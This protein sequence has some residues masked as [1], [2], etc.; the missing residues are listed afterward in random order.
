MTGKSICDQCQLVESLLQAARAAF[1]AS[2]AVPERV[3]LLRLTDALARVLVVLESAGEGPT[4][5]GQLSAAAD[6]LLPVLSQIG[7]L[8]PSWTQR[9]LFALNK[10]LG[11]R[12][13]ALTRS[14]RAGGSMA[15]AG[16]PR[17]APPSKETQQLEPPI[18]DTLCPVRFGA[19]APQSTS[20]G[21]S[22]V[23]RFIA[24]PPGGT[25]A[26]TAALDRPGNATT[27]GV[28]AAET[29]RRGTFLRVVLSAPGLRVEEGAS[30]QQDF[31]WTGEQVLLEFGV[32]IPR[33]LRAASTLLK[34]DVSID[35]LLLA[36]VRLPLNIAR[37][38]DA[39]KSRQ[40]TDCSLV[41]S[42]FASYS[43]KDRERV[44]DRVAA[45]R[46][47]VGTDIFL[48]CHDLRPGEKWNQVLLQEI[49]RREAFILFWSSAAAA[50]DWV[51]WEWQRAIEAKGLEGIQIHPLENGVVVPRALESVHLGDP[52]MDLRAA[53]VAR[54]ASSSRS[55]EGARP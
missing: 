34:F 44:L 30:A 48:D 8:L 28:G 54:Q 47:A 29:V 12:V 1:E 15:L 42:A 9:E 4:D 53:H 46:I 52:Y 37:A 38:A 23:A 26:A 32:S 10:S 20:P 33:R 13:L 18:G 19:S 14:A 36:R 35:G 2:S 50:S 16:P 40:T 24:Y 31:S 17:K 11:A 39:T 41:R 22:F 55:S 27:V 45:I 49:E 3:V 43:S 21:S 5:V 6:E 51:T 7:M 25:A